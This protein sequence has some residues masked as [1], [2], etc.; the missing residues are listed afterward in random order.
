MALTGSILFFFSK[1]LFD[2]F[3]AIKD[4]SFGILKSIFGELLFFGSYKGMS[5]KFRILPQAD[6]TN[7]KKKIIF[8]LVRPPNMGIYCAHFNFSKKGAKKKHLMCKQVSGFREEGRRD[9]EKHTYTRKE[10]FIYSCYI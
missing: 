2:L 1:I 4:L 5:R 6:F 7:K 10:C 3:S 9:W 8:F